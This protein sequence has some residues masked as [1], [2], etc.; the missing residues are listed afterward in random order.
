MCP[1]SLAN[2]AALE[3]AALEPAALP[4]WRSQPQVDTPSCPMG[5][6]GVR[7]KLKRF[8]GRHSGCEAASAWSAQPPPTRN[9]SNA[10]RSVRSNGVGDCAPS[11][12]RSKIEASTNRPCTIHKH[13]G[14]GP[15]RSSPS[16]PGA[17][18]TQDQVPAAG[19]PPG[20]VGGGVTVGGR[21]G[22]L[23]GRVGPVQPV[24]W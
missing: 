17:A 15:P 23:G 8:R 22:R 18:S 5:E 16:P 2:L 6:L 11:T 7:L 21:L 13:P 1:R 3:P 24:E 9:R 20:G 14:I 10:L 19:G 4:S 12:N